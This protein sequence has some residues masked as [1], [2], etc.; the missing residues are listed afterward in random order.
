MDA[1]LTKSL[2]SYETR[3]PNKTETESIMKATILTLAALAGFLYFAAI[4]AEYATNLKHLNQT[5]IE[6]ALAE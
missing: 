6:I 2:V 4:S 5:R 1:P 3:Q